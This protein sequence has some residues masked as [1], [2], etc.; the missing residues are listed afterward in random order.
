MCSASYSTSTVTMTR[1]KSKHRS[2]NK[3]KTAE[4]TESGPSTAPDAAS[5]IGETPASLDRD[6]LGESAADFGVRQGARAPGAEQFRARY[7]VPAAGMRSRAFKYRSEGAS[8][9]CRAG[10]GRPGCWQ[11]GELNAE[12]G[13]QC[14]SRADNDSTCSCFCLLMPR[15]HL[16]AHRPTYTLPSRQRTRTK[17][18]GTTPPR[19]A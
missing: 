6:S 19:R 2:A 14:S 1:T 15:R 8:W 5:L 7:Q 3:S 16:R 12:L 9:Y 18:S 10:G 13:P 4:K 11:T 17:R